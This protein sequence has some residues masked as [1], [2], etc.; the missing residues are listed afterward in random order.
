MNVVI[1][2]W[3]DG[4]VL[5]GNSQPTKQQKGGRIILGDSIVDN[6]II[7]H[8]KVDEDIKNAENYS[9]IT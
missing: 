4:C 5:H 8:F 3:C 1:L 6:K 7:R 2:D 9:K